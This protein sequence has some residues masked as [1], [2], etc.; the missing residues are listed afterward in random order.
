MSTPIESI[1]IDTALLSGSGDTLR[2]AIGGYW[3]EVEHE[4][5]VGLNFSDVDTQ[6]PDFRLFTKVF[7]P[8]GSDNQIESE[9]VDNNILI[10]SKRFPVRIASD[11]TIKDDSEWRTALLGG[12]YGGTTYSSKYN[13]SVFQYLKFNHD[14]PYP[15]ITSTAIY[16]ATNTPVPEIEISCDYSDYLAPYEQHTRQLDSELLIPNYYVFADFT[17]HNFD[18]NPESEALYPNEL[19]NFATLEGQYE[20]ILSDIFE[21]SNSDIPWPVPKWKIDLFDE[22]AQRNTN[23]S[24]QYLTSSLI[25]NTLSSSTT[26]WV[27]DKFQTLLFDQETMHNISVLQNYQECFPYKMK[28]KFPAVYSEASIGVIIQPH[29]MDSINNNNFSPKFIKTLSETFT[30]QIGE[31]IPRSKNYTNYMNYNA[32]VDGAAEYTEE[33]SSIPLRE[34]DYIK[35]LS[36]C[37]NNYI[38]T[39][40]NY[41]FIGD[42][43]LYR[44]AASSKDDTYR[45]INTQTAVGVLNDTISFISNTSN[46]SVL[47]WD[48]LYASN[49]RHTEILAYRVE[50]IGGPSA[51]DNKTQNVLQN[52]WFVSSADMVDF[53]FF[54][55]QVKFDTEY[56]YKVYAYTLTVG[57]KYNTS[58]LRL[59]RQLGCAV[60]TNEDGTDDQVGL[61][62]YDPFSADEPP[63]K[64][65]LPGAYGGA[66]FDE[67]FEFGNDERLY[68]S[69]PFL[70]DFYLNYEPIVKLIEIPLYS[71]T[72]RILDNPTNRLN[73]VPY[74]VKDSSNRIGFDFTYNAFSERTFP[75][76][77]SEEDQT[78]KQNYMH[79]QDLLDDSTL[80]KES[81]SKP[82][83]LEI[84]KLS[85]RPQAVA[86]FN[87]NQI[88]TLDLKIKNSKHTNRMAS[89][90]DRVRPNRKYYYLFRVLN[91]QRNLSHLSE[92]YEAQL[93]NDGG[94]PYTVFNV[95]S[96]PELQEEIFNKTSS[97]FKKLFQLQPNL[98]Q[99]QFNTDDVD[100]DQNAGS[101][102]NNL[103][104][105]TAD[106]LIWDK[107]FKVRLTSKKTGRKIDL[108]ITYYLNSE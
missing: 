44:L 78:Y 74:Q 19:I 83:Y 9:T 108:N 77:I 14:K 47:N 24:T 104:V 21:F 49:E 66:A 29:F 20:G 53:E 1:I 57:I 48:D 81:I 58:D 63:A 41:M 4:W 13:E 11:R 73:I 61:E 43:N 59:T 107:T 84:Y 10:P 75:S 7:L 98:K 95:I 102:I 69:Y 40:Q 17:H 54:D 88:A 87:N 76:L 60:D 65:L 5:G 31:L 27:K 6:H 70:A 90:E 85:K 33:V 51:G 36:H 82:R 52:F 86:E 22:V 101:Q 8:A 2:T 89:Y 56:T 106:D 38:D 103:A 35:F 12:T 23:L 50:K 97:D 18:T 37:Y 72:L 91:E 28:I 67:E 68:S 94:S 79:A 15:K 55:T 80:A 16:N 71:K 25:Q 100:F 46:V 93:I 39:N 32:I 92:I 105:G 64:R 96:E 45:H 99:L 42:S 26:N 30:N 3:Y 34:I 62:F